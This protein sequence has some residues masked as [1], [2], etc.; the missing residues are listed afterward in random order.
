MLLRFT[1]MHGLGNDFVVVDRLSQHVRL[2]KGLV[3]RLGDRRFGIGFDQL[4]VV[5]HPHDP[6]IDFRYQ[7]FN[8]DGNEVAQCGNGA[9]CFAKYVTDKRL[10]GRNPIRVQTNTGTLELQ[11]MKDRQVRVNMGV[12]ELD[13]QGVPFQAQQRALTYMLEVAGRSVELSV[14]ALGNPHAV[15]VVDDC[16]N[17]P[18]AELGEQIGAHEC[19]P[20]GINVGFMQVVDNTNFELRV[21]ERGAG[22]TLACG[23]GAC[24][25]LV[26]GQLRGLL[27]NKACAHLRGGLLQLEWQGEGQ[28]VL[29]TGP[30]TTVYEGQ[31]RI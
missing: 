26:A 23:S 17:A 25:A 22:E 9:R 10:T 19:F 24:A 28:P 18:V 29:M 4:L 12:P 2:N 31:I 30:A 11:I 16:A 15:I 8:N 7:I 14:I 3:K 20:E 13:P 21:F 6:D 1:K 5:D 27:E